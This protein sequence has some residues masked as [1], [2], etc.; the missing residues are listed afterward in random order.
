MGESIEYVCRKI[1]NY[2]WYIFNLIVWVDIYNYNPSR[3]SRGG[4]GW[5]NRR[6]RDKS[7]RIVGQAHSRAYNTRSQLS[8]LQTIWNDDS[9]KFRSSPECPPF[10]NAQLMTFFWI[11]AEAYFFSFIID[12]TLLFSTDSDLEAFSHYPTDGSFAALLFQATAFTN[13]LNQLFLSY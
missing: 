8:R 9:S 6:T 1:C 7:Q 5:T 13:Y 2:I 12:V 11:L 10:T 3:N 4:G